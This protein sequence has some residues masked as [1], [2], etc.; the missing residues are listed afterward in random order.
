MG[1]TDH[2]NR[3]LTE[4]RPYDFYV[5][6]GVHELVGTVHGRTRPYTSIPNDY[7][8]YIIIGLKPSKWTAAELKRWSTAS[9]GGRGVGPKP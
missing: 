3:G 8:A 6:D 2:S 1:R 7:Y 5:T 4:G 9:W